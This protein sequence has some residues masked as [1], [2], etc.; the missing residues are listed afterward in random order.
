MLMKRT[1]A[2]I[3]HC[4]TSNFSLESGVANIR[5]YLDDGIKVGLGTDGK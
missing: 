3:S 1:G 5:Q 2:G 4:P